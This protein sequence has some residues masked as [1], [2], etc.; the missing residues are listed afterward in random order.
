MSDSY[1]Q[2]G[3]SF[4]LPCP[5]P[6]HFICRHSLP[7]QEKT[8]SRLNSWD[9]FTRTVIAPPPPTSATH[10]WGEAHYAMADGSSTAPSGSKMSLQA[11]AQA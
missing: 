2:D 4:C 1:K 6:R 5:K 11:P 7:T 10:E 3:A 8:E 9:V